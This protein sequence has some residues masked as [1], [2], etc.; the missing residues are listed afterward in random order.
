MMSI[1]SKFLSMVAVFTIAFAAFGLARMWYLVRKHTEELTA[2]QAE[3]AL[4]FDLAIRRYVGEVVRP[5]IEQRVASDE[6]IPEIMSTSYVA[7]EV[8]EQVR[9]EFPD[10]V[11]KFSS[12]NPRNP[13]NAAGLEEQK[14]I[15][16]FRENPQATAWRGAISM[17]GREYL[18]HSIPRRMEAACLHCHGGPDAAPASLLARYGRE[19]GFH[20]SV[21]DVAALDTIGIPTDRVHAA[22]NSEAWTH[23]AVLALGIIS[24]SCAF[25]LTYRLLIGD[26]LEAITRHFKSAAAQPE[27]APLSN[28]TIA[29]HDEISVLASTFNALATRLQGVHDSLEQRVRERTANLESEIAE[30]IR[31]EKALRLTH[32]SVDQAMDA[33]IWLDASGHIVFVNQRASHVLGY[34]M[35]ELSSMTVHDVDP[36]FSPTAWRS[37][38]EELR[39]KKSLVIQTVHRTKAGK[40]I[41]VEIAVNHIECDGHEYNCAFARDITERKMA[42]QA[43]QESEK[44]LE[45]ALQG[46]GLGLWDWRI[47]TEEY[48]FDQQWAASIGCAFEDVPATMQDFLTLICPDDRETVRRALESHLQRNA[49]YAPEFRVPSMSGQSVWLQSRG[50]VVERDQDGNPQRMIGIHQDITSRKQAQVELAAAK[51]GAEGANR[52]KSEFLANMSHEIRTPMTAIVGYIDVLADECRRRCPFSHA[53]IGDPLEVILQNATHLLQIIDDVLDLSKIEAGKVTVHK[54]ACSP[55]GIVSEVASLMQLR[56][57]AKG[58]ALTVRYDG[59]IPESIQ[60]DPTRLRQI[61]M[62]IVGNA[63]KFTEVGE[64]CIVTSL[65]RAEN[66]A[67]SLQIRVQDTGIGMDEQLASR[68]FT[69]FTQ[70]DSSNSRR[71]G[72][73]GLGLSISKRLAELLGGDISISSAVG[74][75]SLFQVNVPTGSLEGVRL[76]D[77]PDDIQRQPEKMKARRMDSEPITLHG[78]RVLLAEDGPDNQRLIAF[79]L[80]NAGA[81][82]TVAENG[83]VAL[84]FAW[85]ERE[86]TRPFDLVLMD[87]QMPVLDG[88]ETTRQLRAAG[89]DKPIVALTAHAMKEDRQKCLDAGC[90]DYMAKPI[91]RIFLL[92]TVSRHVVR[93]AMGALPA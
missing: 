59:K 84:Q 16:Y 43:L 1:R 24:I 80:K 93:T 20:W 87:M 50:K 56:A 62:N 30:R 67:P 12:D 35:E 26:R 61:L 21:G 65:V 58:L 25:V 29:G 47:A 53:E 18:V 51:D 28:I 7:R 9:Q 77:S 86:A 14:I 42:E 33:V 27:D 83:A 40:L 41:P 73:T 55:C 54:I 3:L 71:F 36:M 6:F 17:N 85:K 49:H 63:V 74:K 57:T 88:Y 82:V 69:P 70:A 5:L 64:I 45:L 34:S 52:A 44:R 38:W 11:I 92:E 48:T 68:L 2:S 22:I 90:D 60:S 76:L 72:G 89:W 91:D 31:V 32:F 10:Y 8:F 37:H 66:D 46:A 23:L 15:D 81:E 39:E 4:Q 79:L 75:G 78:V 13:A 19:A